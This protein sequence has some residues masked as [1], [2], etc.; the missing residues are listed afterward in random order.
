[1]FCDIGFEDVRVLFLNPV[2]ENFKVL[3]FSLTARE[4]SEFDIV[5]LF[6]TVVGGLGRAAA[7]SLKVG[8]LGDE[9]FN[10]GESLTL[11]EDDESLEMGC[12]VFSRLFTVDSIFNMLRGEYIVD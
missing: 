9:V 4:G 7:G 12:R 3:A 2:S 11:I 10:L 5:A 6:F 8:T 1:M